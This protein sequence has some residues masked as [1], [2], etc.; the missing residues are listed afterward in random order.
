M[1]NAIAP[2]LERPQKGRKHDRRARLGIMQK[3]NSALIGLNAAKRER[4]LLLR[5]DRIPVIRL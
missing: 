2:N 3:H 1:H 5:R 4:Q